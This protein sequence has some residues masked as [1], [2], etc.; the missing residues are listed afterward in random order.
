MG[1]MGIIVGP[2]GSGKTRSVLNLNPDTTV[3]INVLGKDLPFKGSRRVY[4]E[5]KGN[6]LKISQWDEVQET[7]AGISD[8]GP[9]IKHIIVDDARYIMEK[10]L[11][12]KA[13]VTGYGKFTEIALHFQS[14]IETVEHAREDLYVFF[15]M[16]D[17]DITNDK[18]IVGKKCKTVGRMVD[19]HYNPMEVVPVCLYCAPSFGKD[20]KPVYQFYTHKLRINGVEIP[21]KTPEDMFKEDTI[22][23][24][25]DLV[26]RTMEEYYN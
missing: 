17:D 9:E 22:P 15:M 11:F 2:S 21:A 20:G 10:E 25:L 7:I 4:N 6:L 12:Q 19:E 14:I 1:R 8:G 24:D 23:N 26:I 3:L 16:H 5:E 18:A 13:N